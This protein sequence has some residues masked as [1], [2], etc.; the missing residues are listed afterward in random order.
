MQPLILNVDDYD[1]GRYART[2]VL[3][4]AGFS[5]MEAATGRE[6]VRLVTEHHPSLILLDVNLPDINGF[7]VCRQIK[8]NPRTKA[9]TVVHISASSVLTDHQVQG[10]ECGADSYLVE[11]IDPR[12]LIATVRAFLRARAAEDALRRSNEE[13]QWFAYRVAHDLDEPLRTV[14][15]HVQL[16]E[17]DLAKLDDDQRASMHFVVSGAQRMRSF[18]DDLLHY[19]TAANSAGP[20]EMRSSEALV[21]LAVTNLETMIQS[22]G[23]QITYDPLP[24]VPSQGGLEHV[25]QN[26]IANAIKYGREGVAPSI[27][28]SATVDNGIWRFAV[29]DNGIGVKPEDQER[30]FA[31]FRRLHESNA[32]GNGIGLAIVQRIVQAHGGSIWVDS[33]PGKGSTFRFTVAR[34][35]VCAP[36]LPC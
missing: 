35:S 13:L 4:Q 12:V 10:L 1:P 9:S 21:K 22:T 31:V 20:I 25:F 5:V 8:S 6:T 23:A 18:I 27:H 28:I 29:Q 3:K 7:E 32:P 36:A 11:P 34:E 30:I 16:L 2:K 14:T 17:R 24:I 19:A 26:L 33:E 15:S